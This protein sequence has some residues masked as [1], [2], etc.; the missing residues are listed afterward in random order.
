[1]LC[2]AS[3][4][5]AVA[6]VSDGARSCS[7]NFLVAQAGPA[8]T[9]RAVDVE[10]AP[11][12]VCRVEPADGLLAHANHFVDADRLGIWQPI[13]EEKRSTYHR[14]ARM[15]RLLSEGA[16]DGGLDADTLRRAL[17]DHDEYPNSV[18]RH[19]NESLPASERYQTVLS[20]I[21]D[22]HARSMLV[23][24]GPPC[25]RDYQEFRL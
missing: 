3:L 4:G 14:C 6:A 15:Q 18:C 7:A 8:G 16:R 23:A 24:A 9:G 12:A 20:T 11:H 13:V 1:V 17:R 2:S 5:D 19:P 22:L 25:E 21:I 10:A